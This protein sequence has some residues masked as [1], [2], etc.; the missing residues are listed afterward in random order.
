[1]IGV[2]AVFVSSLITV[3]GAD[4][5]PYLALYAPV[6][7]LAGWYL[8]AWHA[9]LAV[10]L[11][12]ATELWRATV[13]GDG[14]RVEHLAV[15]LP[16]FALLTLLA[17]MTSDRLTTVHVLGRRDQLRTAATL[18]AIRR[19]DELDRADASDPAAVVGE[20]F[21]SAA[22]F[23]P[24][25]GA[26]AMVTHRCDDA[27]APECHATVAVRSGGAHAGSLRLCRELPF[28]TTERRLVAILAAV[29]GRALASSVARAEPAAH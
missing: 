13:L 18:D 10:A 29:A 19:L 12:A 4:A 9:A 25:G 28:S 7:A 2:Q 27:D 21:E 16:V 20:V 6:L 24:D 26:E 23:V 8:R 3:T 5:S 1:M 11:V 15:S 22:T 17:R 14:A